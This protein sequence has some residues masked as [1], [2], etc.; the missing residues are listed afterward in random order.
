MV[1]CNVLQC[2]LF[3]HDTFLLLDNYRD[4]TDPLHWCR[5]WRC[6]LSSIKSGCVCV[7][8]AEHVEAER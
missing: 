5:T 4:K 7:R 2:I 1:Y 8:R 3:L 6:E